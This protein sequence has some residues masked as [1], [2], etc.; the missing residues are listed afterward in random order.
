MKIFISLIS[1]RKVNK[2]PPPSILACWWIHKHSAS[3]LSWPPLWPS[4][5]EATPQERSLEAAHWKNKKTKTKQK[6]KH[7]KPQTNKKKPHN[8]RKTPP[9]YMDISNLDCF[10]VT[11]H[12]AAS[13]RLCQHSWGG[14]RACGTGAGRSSW[15][16]AGSAL[17][18]FFIPGIFPLP[19]LE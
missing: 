9:H 3:S 10:S 11:I 17:K 7:K 13:K 12:A 18:P 6:I 16:A 5:G 2:Y 15:G 19:A 8:Q 4:T 1:A 14:G